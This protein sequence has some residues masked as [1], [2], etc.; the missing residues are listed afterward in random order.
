MI[1]Q[2]YAV[3]NQR[4]KLLVKAFKDLKDTLSAEQKKELKEMIREKYAKKCGTGKATS[5]CTKS[6]SKT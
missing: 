5:K 4:A 1:D 2:K 6:A 3:K